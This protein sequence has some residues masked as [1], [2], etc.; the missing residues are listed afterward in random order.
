MRVDTLQC[1]CLLSCVS[2]Q[3]FTPIEHNQLENVFN[4]RLHC[5]INGLYLI[6][7]LWKHLRRESSLKTDMK[8]KLT[9]LLCRKVELEI[10][11]SEWS[12]L[13][14]FVPKLVESFW[15]DLVVRDIPVNESQEVSPALVALD[16]LHS[17]WHQPGPLSPQALT[18]DGAVVV[19][20]GVQYDGAFSKM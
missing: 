13:N 12:I 2:C 7:N 9:H 8:S 5:L 18:V 14:I 20:N 15:D 10:N 1:H 3:L 19:E 16:V 11:K 6:Y 4:F 17:V